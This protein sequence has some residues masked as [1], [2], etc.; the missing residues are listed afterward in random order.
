MKH[1]LTSQTRISTE[2]GFTLIEL[3]VVIG[4]IAVLSSIVLVS[5]SQARGKG[6]DAA[7]KANLRTLAV[8]AE[9]IREQDGQYTG[10]GEGTGCNLFGNTDLDGIWVNKTTADAFGAALNGSSDKTK[11][12][13]G[14]WGDS[15]AVA[16][17]R[18][19]GSPSKY[20]CV[21]SEGTKCGTNTTAGIYGSSAS[22][23][24]ACASYQ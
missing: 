7:I 9:V 18:P 4:I 17:L 6:N 15:W 20:W 12:A 1:T 19:A 8:Q 5:L 11:A 21:D 16:I 24:G 14:V 2:R 13:C 3:L 10:N 23:C 22:S